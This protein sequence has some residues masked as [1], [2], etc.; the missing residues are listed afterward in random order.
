MRSVVNDKK[1]VQTK[2]TKDLIVTWCQGIIGKWI[3]ENWPE[4]ASSCLDLWERKIV[5]R[6]KVF[7]EKN[8]QC[9]VSCSSI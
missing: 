2:E 3:V 6:V 8:E 5:R 9:A 1:I 7:R 4:A